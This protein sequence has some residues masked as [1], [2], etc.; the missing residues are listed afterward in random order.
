MEVPYDGVD[1]VLWRLGQWFVFI[2]EVDFRLDTSCARGNVP[3]GKHV[4]K[5][6]AREAN[7]LVVEITQL[8]GRKILAVH[9]HV[10][11][12]AR[13]ARQV[14]GSLADILRCAL[15]HRNEIRQWH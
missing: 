1:Q 9:P 13:R 10:H 3:G 2:G 8:G 12:D 14:P 11:D 6:Q 7:V 5:A 4:R 15:Y